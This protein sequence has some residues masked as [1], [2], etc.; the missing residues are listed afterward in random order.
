MFGSLFAP[1]TEFLDNQSVLVQFFI[2]AGMV[3]Y[4][5]TNGAFHLDQIIL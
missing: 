4:V 3:V 1:L 2:L 5:M